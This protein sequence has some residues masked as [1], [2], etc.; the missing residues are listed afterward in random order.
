MAMSPNC[1]ED[2]APRKV[3][4]RYVITSAAAAALLLGLPPLT[5]RAALARDALPLPPR[6]P[7]A[8]PR[9][10][11]FSKAEFEI[12]DAFA[13]LLIPADAQSGGAR[14]AGVAAV[15][16]ERLAESRD[17]AWRQ[18]WHDDIAE[19]DRLSRVMFRRRFMAATTA[20]RIAL[21]ERISRNEA[22]PKEAG[23]YAFG[24]FKWSIAD[25]Y[26]RTRIGIHD[27]LQY[28]GNVLQDE[29]AGTDV[30]AASRR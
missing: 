1:P 13:E 17:P 21:M 29:F 9:L 12:I 27:D 25:I 5:Y 22:D 24:T 7:S 8:R 30:G 19:I 3:G 16:D 26:Y 2:A 4:R 6:N 20:Q 23:E 18:S 28:Q 15:L 11:F 14:A 10:R